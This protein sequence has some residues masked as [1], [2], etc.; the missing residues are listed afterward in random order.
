MYIEATAGESIY[1]LVDR[2]ITH[3][4]TYGVGV[5]ICHNDIDVR[6]YPGSHEYDIMEKIELK[7]QL[8]LACQATDWK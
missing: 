7:R 1:N 3:C 6:V 2:A 8:V 5:V 4:N